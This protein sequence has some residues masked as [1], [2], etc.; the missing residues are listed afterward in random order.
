LFCSLRA[1]SSFLSLQAQPLRRNAV[2]G[3]RRRCTRICHYMPR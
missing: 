3:L 1:G 2:P